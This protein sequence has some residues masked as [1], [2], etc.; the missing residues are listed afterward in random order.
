MVL[1]IGYCTAIAWLLYQ[2]SGL[3]V[4]EPQHAAQQHLATA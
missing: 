2:R 1:A 4:E 3:A